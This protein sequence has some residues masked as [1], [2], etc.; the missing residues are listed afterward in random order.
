MLTGR[1][2]QIWVILPSSEIQQLFYFYHSTFGGN[3]TL[4][5]CS[6]VF[7]FTFSH[8]WVA[9]LHFWTYFSLILGTQFLYSISRMFN[10]QKS[11][12]DCNPQICS[13][14]ENLNIV[15]GP[16]K[17]L[18]EKSQVCDFSESLKRSGTVTLR[19]M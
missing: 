13:L 1:S 14:W 4:S 10:P 7:F 15:E 8:I 9:K 17:L 3:V 5:A 2:C 19:S 6:K 16:A 11:S 12:M 18:Y